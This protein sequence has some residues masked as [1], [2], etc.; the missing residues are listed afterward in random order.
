MPC[1]LTFASSTGGGRRPHHAQQHQ[2]GDEREDVEGVG[3]RQADDRDQHAAQRRAGDHADGEAQGGDRRGGRHLVAVDQARRESFQRRA[4]QAVKRG[5]DRRDHEQHPQLRAGQRGV[6][7]QHD[8]CAGEGQLGQEQ[9]PPAVTRVGQRPS[10]E[11]G[12]QQRAQLC[13]AQQAD[14]Q[15]GAG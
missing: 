8:R 13:Q 3:E 6:Q 9:H 12:D 1:R 14:H 15:R 5:R 10:Q 4:L 7:Q 2:R 11:R